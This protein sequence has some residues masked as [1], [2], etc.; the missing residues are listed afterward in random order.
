MILFRDWKIESRGLLAR[1]F[2]NLSRR[3]EVTGDLPEGWDWT[4]LV[5]VGDA[6]D[7]IP[8][9]PMD[10][11][12]GHTLTEE[13]L[14]LSGYYT[15]QL[16]GT[17]GEV[18]KHTNIIR[19]FVSESLSGSCQWPTVPSEFL[20]VERRI[21]ELNEHPP[22]PS[23]N[24]FW[25]I[26][27]PDKEKYE[28][29]KCSLPEGGSTNVTSE[30]ITSAL[31]YIPAEAEIVRQLSD[32]KLDRHRKSVVTQELPSMS[33]T[34]LTGSETWTS[35]GW[36]GSA[37]DGWTHTT[38]NTNALSVLVS[39][40]SEGLYVIEFDANADIASN[41]L[42]V[43]LGDS[44]AFDIYWGGISQHYVV[45]AKVSS[46]SNLL[47]IPASNYAG[48]IR[49]ITV[50]QITGTSAEYFG[51]SDSDN[52]ISQQF[53]PTT[54]GRGSLYIG[55]NAGQFDVHGVG[56]VGIGLEALSSNIS[57][58]WN[59]AVGRLAM[60]DNVSG[61][62]N[63]A[64]GQST[65]LNNISGHRNIAVGSYVLNANRT[66][67]WNVG[68]G[69]DA[70]HDNTVGNRNVALGFMALTNNIS[71]NENVAVGSEAAHGLTTGSTNVA[72]GP[73]SM[74]YA[75]TGSNNLALGASALYRNNTGSNNVAIGA[76]AGR[77][78]GSAGA[79]QQNVFIGASS[80]LN[81]TAGCA[82]NVIIGTGAAASLTNGTRCI[83][84]G[85]DCDIT[86]SN[87]A[88]NIGNLLKGSMRPEH[89]YLEVNGGLQINALPTTDPS[90]AGHLW[91]DSG[92]VKVSAG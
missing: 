44:P 57:G 19:V 65:L 40:V 43:T 34:L 24:G 21:A 85:A 58:F 33:E 72:V 61:S 67:N 3:L 42:M 83:V 39:S 50:R 15:M 5:Q 90:I 9:E 20:E 37:A 79:Y 7:I 80:A 68:V 78:G 71:G 52:S 62:R 32:E 48:T 64:V 2:D 66:G 70:L 88:L 56:S 49:N 46:G 55:K 16:R 76:R 54:A 91:N 47:F 26:W 23:E 89:K 14:S 45:G 1:Q 18:V 10:G 69:V 30:N 29:S 73:S 53:R 22:V 51:V 59:V 8:L 84:I 6:M 4:M 27:N 28:D 75:T 87:Y 74:M 11:G 31:G 25:M 41:A 60:R 17:R 82:S 81:I 12:A 36:A 63:V 77:G 35:D 92:T 38:G 86:N 13:Q